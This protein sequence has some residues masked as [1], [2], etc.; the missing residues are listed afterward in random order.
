MRDVQAGLV[1]LDIGTMTLELLTPRADLINL[2]AMIGEEIEFHTFFYLESQGQGNT[3]LPRII[4]F[5][6]VADRTFFQQFTKVRGIGNRKALRAMAISTPTILRAIET[7]DL[8]LL[9]SLPEVGKRTAEAIVS[10]LHDKAPDLLATF[11]TTHAHQSAQS[12]NTSK[13]QT[14]TPTPSGSQTATED[15]AN[16]DAFAI[17]AKR[18]TMMQDAIAALTQLGESRLDAAEWVEQVIVKNP[19]IET[20]E[21][22]VQAVYQNRSS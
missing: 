8:A 16:T 4:G 22:L 5:N 14:D 9:K 15:T 19:E 21:D 12:V 13:D 11:A 1:Y 20:A 6:S 17:S 7:R 2:Q 18:N 3:F 10:E